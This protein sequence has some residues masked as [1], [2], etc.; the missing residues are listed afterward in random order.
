MC[1]HTAGERVLDTRANQ[2]LTYIHTAIYVSSYCAPH[3]AGE[4][5]LDTRANQALALYATGKTKVFFPF[6]FCVN[7]ALVLY[8]T[9][10]TEVLV[11]VIY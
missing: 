2:A 10:N 5:A 6:F 1:P 4:R 3:A 8:A 11:S 9:G 7:Q